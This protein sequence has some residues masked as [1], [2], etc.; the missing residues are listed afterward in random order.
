MR[1]AE[2]FVPDLDANIFIRFVG[3]CNAELGSG[4]ISVKCRLD[5][6]DLPFTARSSIVEGTERFRISQIVVPS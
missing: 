1:Y 4:L 3:S 6:I 5:I 2:L